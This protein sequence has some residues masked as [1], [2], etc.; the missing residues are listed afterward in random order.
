MVMDTHEPAPGDSPPVCARGF[1]TSLRQEIPHQSVPVDAPPVCTRGFPTSL[2]KGIPRQF[3]PGDFPSVKL[4]L[5]VITPETGMLFFTF[6]VPL[7][8]NMFVAWCV[9]SRN[10]F[11]VC[12]C[13]VIENTTAWNKLE[14]KRNLY[15]ISRNSN[16][17]II[18]SYC[19]RDQNLTFI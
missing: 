1:P 3:A 14:R 5:P 4:Q 18:Q 12:L 17:N 19:R 9:T 13:T 7:C 6:S 2:R 15:F 8:L 16:Y 10:C 11:V